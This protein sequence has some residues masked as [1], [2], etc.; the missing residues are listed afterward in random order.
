MAATK[1][2]LEQALKNIETVLQS[3]QKNAY[4]AAKQYSEDHASRL[5][6]EVGFLNGYIKQV[7]AVIEECK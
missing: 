4:D 2:Q 1:S 7:L 6:F 3:A 5:A